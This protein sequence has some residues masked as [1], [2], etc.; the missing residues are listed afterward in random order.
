MRRAALACA[1][2]LAACAAIAPGAPLEVREAARSTYCNTPGDA[3]AAGLLP[4]VAAVLELQAARGIVLLAEDAI[5][6]APHALVEMGM[7]STGGYAVAVAPA[8]SVQDG[9]VVLVATFTQPQP[10]SLRTQALSSPC[11]LV[12]LPPG[13]YAGVEVRD[14]GGAV[15]ARGGRVSLERGSSGPAR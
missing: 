2:V 9:H 11:V 14:A 4:D 6:P 8:A 12:Q 13:D 15:R 7:R 3:P 10:G 1:P 5:A